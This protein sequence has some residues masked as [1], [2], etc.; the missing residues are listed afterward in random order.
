M[1]AENF[2][3]N[4]EPPASPHSKIPSFK[5]AA[6]YLKN[7]GEIQLDEISQERKFLHITCDQYAL[8]KGHLKLKKF[9]KIDSIE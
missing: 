7:T 3:Q 8:L 6:L 4:T 9:V 5:L 2:K 1:T